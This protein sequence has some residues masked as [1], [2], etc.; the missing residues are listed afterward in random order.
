MLVVGDQRRRLGA[1]GSR[2]RPARSFLRPSARSWW[3]RSSR[4]TT[5]S[6]SRRTRPSGCSRALQPEVHCKGTDYG[7]PER[8]P[9]YE[10][11]QRLRRRDRAGGRSQGPRHAGSDRHGPGAAS[12]PQRRR[13]RTERGRICVNASLMRLLRLMRCSHPDA[14]RPHQLARRHRP[15]PAGAAGAAPGASRGAASAGWSRTCS[16]RSWCTTPTSTTC[17][18]WGCGVGAVAAQ[19]AH[20]ARDAVEPRAARRVGARCRCST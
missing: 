2:D 3:R 10:R 18:R 8:V 17:S 14:P 5:S 9:E 7:S 13:P 1:R 20:A 16:R 6:S 4:S 12:A 19:P 11:G 15:L